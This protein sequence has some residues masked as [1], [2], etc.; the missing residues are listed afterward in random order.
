MWSKLPTMKRNTLIALIAGLV[1]MACC[2]CAVVAGGIAIFVSS[3]SETGGLSEFFPTDDN[4]RPQATSQITIGETPAGDATDEPQ[5]DATATPGDAQG[6]AATGT[7]QTENGGVATAGSQSNLDAAINAVLPREDLA[8]LAVR[9][10][11]VAKEQTVVSCTEERG[12]DVGDTR[13]FIMSN[14]D[15]NT[16]FEIETRLEHETDHVYMWVQTKPDAVEI[17]LN[18]LRRAADDFEAEIYPRTREFF[19]SEAQPGVDCDPHVHVVHAMGVGS[20]VGG[21]FSSPDSY[22]KAVRS[23]SNEGQVFVMHA[24]PGYNGSDPGGD[25]YMS[26]MAHEFQHMISFN[27]N[28]AP[29]L[30]L[31]EGAA[32][33]AERLNGFG[34]KIGTTFEFAAR[35]ETQ[36]NTWEESSAGA[37]GA[38]YGAGYLFWSYLYDRFGEETIKKLARSPERSEQAIMRIL[39]ESG[40]TNPDTN[41]AFT[42][43]EIF[44]DFVIANYM[45]KT[46]IEPEG[47]RYNYA[48]ISVPPMAERANYN[49]NDYPLD[50]NDTLAQ[51][52]THYIELR[53]NDKVTIDFAG[54]TTVRMLPMSSSDGAFWWS[55]RSDVSNPRLTREFD[56]SNTQSATLKFRAWYRLERDYDYAYVSVST[57]GGTTWQLVKTQTCTT[58]NPQNANLGCG[59]NGPSGTRDA[60][61]EPRWVDEQADLSAF[62]GKKVLVR[63]EMVTDAGVNREGLAIDN[64]EVPEI[65][66]KD[67]A[68][69]SGDWNAEG[70]VRIDNTLPQH[71]SV[72]LIVIKRDGTRELRRMNIDGGAGQLELDLARAGGI[73]NAVLVISPITQVTTEPASYQ[74]KI[75]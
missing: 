74:L 55:N 38:H 15:D 45:N 36:L 19:G 52:G 60:D 4:P 65:G 51:F 66:F 12:Y 59:W 1:V 42:F 44:A 24:A 67:D 13:T 11:G 57:D 2:A 30:W 21:Y 3:S 9:F 20:S 62:A 39:A 47:N 48:S 54:A 46:K 22:P 64:I 37:N 50:V 58:E 10:K 26:T 69:A 8:D 41:K 75:Q 72:Q 73:R 56:L 34:G 18:R 16:Q 63:F 49:A 40:V 71:W 43:E 35:P 5:G 31:E 6:D 14:Q 61:A 32:Q 17:N 23:D 25:T 53:G 70:W 27:N 68:S 28:H 7:P 33:F 29:D